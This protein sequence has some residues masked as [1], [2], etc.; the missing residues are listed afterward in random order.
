VGVGEFVV[1]GTLYKIKK[2]KVADFSVVAEVATSYLLAM[3]LVDV[4]KLVC[5]QFDGFV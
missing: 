1:I 4:D 3:I 5:C 2:Y